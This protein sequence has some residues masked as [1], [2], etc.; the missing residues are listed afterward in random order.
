MNEEVVNSVSSDGSECNF[1]AK[2]SNPANMSLLNRFMC[3]CTAK[4]VMTLGIH[5]QVFGKFRL[6]L[7]SA[8]KKQ[9][10]TW[11]PKNYVGLFMIGLPNEQVAFYVHETQE[12]YSM[13][14][15]IDTPKLPDGTILCLNYTEDIHI[16]IDSVAVKSPRLLLFDIVMLNG[17]SIKAN[18]EERY[19]LLRKLYDDHFKMVRSVSIL[20]TLQWVGYNTHADAFLDGTI[21]LDHKVG[22]IMALT[23][24]ALRPIRT[25]RIKLP[26]IV[27][28]Q[29]AFL[30]E[31]QKAVPETVPVK[32]CRSIEGYV[33]TKKILLHRTRNQK[34]SRSN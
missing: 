28:D 13:S 33:R 16:G 18:A 25:I 32:T 5:W 1:M 20:F 19:S 10:S 7:G 30:R 17:E 26:M 29:N 15:N 12:M 21:K 34:K 6:N 31:L 9:M 2:S 8:G 22:G 4:K 14:C 11:Y 23:D 24:N 27:F 3:M